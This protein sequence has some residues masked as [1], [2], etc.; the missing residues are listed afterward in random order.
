MNVHTSPMGIEGRITNIK[1]RVG[2]FCDLEP[3]KKKEILKN[4]DKAYLR[5][6]IYERIIFRIS[7]AEPFTDF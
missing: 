6:K 1:Q 2:N 7:G 5:Y 3:E 4:I